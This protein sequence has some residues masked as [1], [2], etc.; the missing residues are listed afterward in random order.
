MA[1]NVRVDSTPKDRKVLRSEYFPKSKKT[2]KALGS[3]KIDFRPA[4][5]LCGVNVKWSH[6]ESI[7]ELKP[8]KLVIFHVSAAP[9]LLQVLIF[10]VLLGILCGSHTA[11]C[12]PTSRA[13]TLDLISRFYIQNF[14]K[15]QG[16]NAR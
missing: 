16:R 1:N 12:F 4:A 11:C 8:N 5:R 9:I 6:S 13:R 10:H 7:F 14:G 3:Y 15:Q 2:A